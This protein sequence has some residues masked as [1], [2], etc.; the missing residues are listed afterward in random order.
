MHVFLPFTTYAV[1]PLKK[2]N[3][4]TNQNPTKLQPLKSDEAKATTK[5]LPLSLPLVHVAAPDCPALTNHL[6]PP[7]HFIQADG[8]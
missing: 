6:P 5:S 1:P 2:T 7:T 4:K 8:R 3:R